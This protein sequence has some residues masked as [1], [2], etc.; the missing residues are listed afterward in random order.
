MNT[1][2]HEDLKS[3]AEDVKLAQFLRDIYKWEDDY[4]IS[5]ASRKILWENKLAGKDQDP[6]WLDKYRDNL[7][8]GSSGE[9]HQCPPP[10]YP[11]P[12]GRNWTRNCV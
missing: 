12:G 3:M 2:T 1:Y 11:A 6:K 5:Y 9:V 4:S 7:R 10:G 8:L